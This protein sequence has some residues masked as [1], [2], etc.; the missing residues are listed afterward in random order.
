MPKWVGRVWFE[1]V[2]EL[3]AWQA[4]KGRKPRF[5]CDGGEGKV[6]LAHAHAQATGGQ[7]IRNRVRAVCALQQQQ[8][9]A[10]EAS[11]EVD[12]SCFAKSR[13]VTVLACV[14]MRWMRSRSTA[15][16]IEIDSVVGACRRASID[17]SRSNCQ[18]PISIDVESVAV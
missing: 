17:R 18:D 2:A 16:S 8:P 3:G 11:T 5:P 10:R 1:G 9:P 7:R 13:L 15:A 14:S 6:T 4:A 12:P